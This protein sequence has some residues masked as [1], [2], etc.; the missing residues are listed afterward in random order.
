[1]NVDLFKGL[2]LIGPMES[3]ITPLS[4][5]AGALM[6]ASVLLALKRA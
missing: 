1:V 5:T 6:N 4:K 2:A 3:M